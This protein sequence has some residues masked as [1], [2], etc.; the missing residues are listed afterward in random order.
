MITKVI[1]IIKIEKIEFEFE[2]NL[3]N[4]LKNIYNYYNY[5]YSFKEIYSTSTLVL[6]VR[7][8]KLGLSYVNQVF[9]SIISDFNHIND[10]H[11]FCII[12]RLRFGSFIILFMHIMS[13][14][15]T[16]NVLV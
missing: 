4:S 6:F 9:N 16:I 10:E 11:R 12:L 7:M 1:F 3:D 2:L 15:K 8:C 13:F 14:I 5:F